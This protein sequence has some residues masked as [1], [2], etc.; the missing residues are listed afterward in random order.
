[1]EKCNTFYRYVR[2]PSILINSLNPSTWFTYRQGQHNAFY[3]PPTQC[4]Y[5]FCMDLRTNKDNFLVLD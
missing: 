4:I 5:V 1:M 3:V 2:Q